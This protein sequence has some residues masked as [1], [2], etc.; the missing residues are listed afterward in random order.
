M[1]R[2]SFHGG[3]LTLVVSVVVATT[4]APC[5]AQSAAGVWRGRW[6]AWATPRRPAH[7]G[8][9]N[10]RLRPAGPCEYRGL[11]YG[12]FAGVIPY[13]YRA[14]VQRQGD[15]LVS[16]KRLGPRRTYA[17]R[18]QLAGNRMWGTW[19]TA[20]GAGTVQLRRRR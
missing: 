20:D 9:L 17:L 7:S 10:V 1:I 5:S 19:N 14:R 16:V 18:L 3:L 12:R 15:T 13:V 2:K 6:Y 4:A 8:T 11:F